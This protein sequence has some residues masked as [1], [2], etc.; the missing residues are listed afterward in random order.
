MTSQRDAT[1]QHIILG[2]VW[3]AGEH[4]LAPALHTGGDGSR[5]TLLHL[6]RGGGTGVLALDMEHAPAGLLETLQ[7]T[8]IAAGWAVDVARAR[9][10]EA[11]SY[12]PRLAVLD[13]RACASTGVLL[14]PWIGG[15]V[16]PSASYVSTD[17]GL[18]ELLQ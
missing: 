15:T 12:T 18:P 3:P 13:V 8:L 7:A 14:T 10:D 2:A 9:S 11:A 4:Y 1:Y 16:W 17:H 5:I 6:R